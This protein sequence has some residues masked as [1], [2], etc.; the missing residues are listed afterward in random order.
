M[1]APGRFDKLGTMKHAALLASLALL[2]AARGAAHAETGRQ[3][4]GYLPESGRRSS[5]VDHGLL[6]LSVPREP[7]ARIPGGTF[8]MG[9]TPL[10][11]Q[12]AANAC[13]NEIWRDAC[14]R[15]F[16]PF[17][18]AEGHIHEVEISPFDIDRTEVTVEAYERCVGAGRCGRPSF[19]ASD[20]RFS[21]PRLPVTHVA[22]DEAAAYCAFVGG[23]LPT[24]AEFELAAKGTEG[25][26]YPW[27][28]LWNPHL[29]NHGALA[30]DR[31]NA[32]DGYAGL[33]EVGAFPDGASPQGVLDLAGNV[34][35]WVSDYAALDGDGF[36]YPGARAID[37]KG[38]PT[39]PARIARGGS[40]LSAA[41]E[42]R[43]TARK[44]VPPLASSE[45]G[46]RC[47]YPAKK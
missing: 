39:G 10:E 27:G 2:V 13:Q 46:F 42:L 14:E 36:G 3:G 16:V 29:A 47:V 43:T 9:S 41:F 35:E 34:A 32:R 38:P 37:P 5:P 40:Y 25:R 23:R 1:Y 18:R 11:M 20:P 31:T 4:W 12:L 15:S 6:V 33:A 19:A 8:N 44:L 30:A 24:E 22:L 45:I 7:K 17:I 21:R 26:R 28:R